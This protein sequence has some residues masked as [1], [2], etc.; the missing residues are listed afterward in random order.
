MNCDKHKSL[1]L[2]YLVMLLAGG[3]IPFRVRR[4]RRGEA[5]LYRYAV[6]EQ[7]RQ[8]P[9]ERDRERGVGQS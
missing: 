3:V 5:C 4:G 7:G 2:V 9:V 1:E 8:R 6:T